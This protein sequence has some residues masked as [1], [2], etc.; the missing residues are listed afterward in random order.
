MYPAADSL[1]YMPTMLRSTPPPSG[2]PLWK[3]SA[4]I[5]VD[6]SQK[7]FLLRQVLIC[8]ICLYCFAM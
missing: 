8:S 5:L 3:R 6:V 2:W 4:M 1:T 7:P